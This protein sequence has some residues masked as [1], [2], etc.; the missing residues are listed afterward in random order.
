MATSTISS[1][2]SF[3]TLSSCP[4]PPLAPKS[5]SQSD[6][7]PISYRR[8]H[9][10]L[11][12]N[13][14]HLTEMCS[15]RS[16][17]ELV[18]D[19]DDGGFI[20]NFDSL[21]A[22]PRTRLRSGSNSSISTI[23]PPSELDMRD[24]A[25]AWRQSPIIPPLIKPAGKGCFTAQ[26]EGAPH[27]TSKDELPEIPDEEPSPLRSTSLAPSIKR[28]KVEPTRYALSLHPAQH[29]V[30]F[31][32]LPTN[33]YYIWSGTL[34]IIDTQPHLDPIR[35]PISNLSIECSSYSRQAR[36]SPT[37]PLFVV[38]FA[39]SKVARDQVPQMMDCSK[40]I[41]SDVTWRREACDGTPV[42]V[43]D[44]ASSGERRVHF[45]DDEDQAVHEPQLR[46]SRWSLQFWVP[47]PIAL[48][49]RKETRKFKLK[50]KASFWSGSFLDQ[51]PSA[52]AE[53]VEVTVS[54]LHWDREK[55]LAPARR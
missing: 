43:D 2:I 16:S 20:F 4:S 25:D 17:V 54:H 3:P 35:P 26:D 24:D 48:F 37:S 6:Q 33:L 44:K 1:R 14:Q 28:M 41:Y 47:I 7:D 51:P 19:E 50:S 29:H 8:Q 52:V 45:A 18:S 34:Y 40:G 55:G 39:E 30:E 12:I 5:G 15:K 22:G 32:D 9:I 46:P 49:S 23:C 21:S 31:W 38:K 36:H 42:P 10:Q 11:F 53:D 27:V 13:L